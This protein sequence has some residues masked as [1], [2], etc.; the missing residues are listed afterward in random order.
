ML[1]THPPSRLPV[2]VARGL[3]S[4]VRAVEVCLPP[5]HATRGQDIYV[6]QEQLK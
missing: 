2:G 1:Q 3:I 6:V 4:A 5:L